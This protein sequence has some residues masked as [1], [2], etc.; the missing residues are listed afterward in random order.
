MKIFFNDN[1]VRTEDRKQTVKTKS[2]WIKKYEILLVKV[3][4]KKGN[5]K[6]SRSSDK[7]KDKKNISRKT[8]EWVLKNAQD[9]MSNEC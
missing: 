5:G 1:V 7:A 2:N 8:K 4:R 6:A 3:V 9:K